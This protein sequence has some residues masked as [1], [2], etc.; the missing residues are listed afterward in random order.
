MLWQRSVL[1]TWIFILLLCFLGVSNEA[2]EEPAAFDGSVLIELA[3]EGLPP[4][5][6][7]DARL[8]VALID[9]SGD[10][11]AQ[12]DAWREASKPTL[13]PLIK[14]YMY[15]AERLAQPSNG[16]D[17]QERLHLGA[18]MRVLEAQKEEVLNAY[19]VKIHN[20][21]TSQTKKR[22]DVA[23]DSLPAAFEA[24]SPGAY[25]AYATLTVK[26]TQF[27]W[28]EPFY[29]Q[30]GDGLTIQFTRNN[31]KNP[32]WTDVNW[33]SFMNLDFSKHHSIPYNNG[34]E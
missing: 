12:I 31:V 18:E 24:L 3:P 32:D 21:L 8:S 5:D 6:V 16:A 26:T 9:D 1:M 15:L 4:L 22:I 25:R 14:R 10:V 7:A 17:S 23:V 2:V 29:I 34:N 33:W 30:G 13:E 27:H 20:L 28:F 11:L 19:H